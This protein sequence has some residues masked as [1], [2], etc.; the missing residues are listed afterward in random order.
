MQLMFPALIFVKSFWIFRSKNDLKESVSTYGS[1]IVL[2]N[3]HNNAIKSVV[4]TI[5]M[6]GT[7]IAI[8]ST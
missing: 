2:E 5:Y 4:S 7:V 8:S 6:H 1:Y 3:S